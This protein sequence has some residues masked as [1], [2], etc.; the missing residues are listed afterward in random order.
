MV[1]HYFELETK[2]R[3][4]LVP[5]LIYLKGLDMSRCL[6]EIPTAPNWVWSIN[7]KGHLHDHYVLF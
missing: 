4:Q 5:A 7:V 6:S 2:I 3:E 1:L